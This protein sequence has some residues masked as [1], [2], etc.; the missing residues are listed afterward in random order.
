MNMVISENTAKN[1]AVVN[2]TKSNNYNILEQYKTSSTDFVAMLNS[3]MNPSRTELNEEELFADIISQ[4]LGLLNQ[5]AKDFYEERTLELSTL[6]ARKDGYVSVEDV[7]L[8]ALSLTEEA[9]LIDKE[10]A[11]RINGEAFALAQLDDNLSALWDGR[12]SANDPSIIISGK[13]DAMARLQNNIER[14]ELGELEAVSR[15]TKEMT[16]S[17]SSNSSSSISLQALSHTVDPSGY[18]IMNMDGAGGFLWKPESES[19]GKLVVLL[20]TEFKGKIQGAEIHSGLPADSSTLLGAGRFA[21]DTHNGN[22]VH[23]RF[24][25]EG[26]A[27]GKEVYVVAKT[28]DGESIAWLIQNGADR[29]D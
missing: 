1:E 12:G 3:A 14:L 19:D 5:E 25:K 29:N 6:R 26:S 22:R 8:E 24:D 10:V 2:N 27:Y 4:K 28:I 9:G 16:M 7:A 20:P 17:H 15:S 13:D 21:G 18:K 11:E 23:Y